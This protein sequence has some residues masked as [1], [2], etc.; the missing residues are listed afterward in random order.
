MSINDNKKEIKAKKS[1]S[2]DLGDKAFV[3]FVS[4]T[5]TWPLEYTKFLRQIPLYDY[6]KE[7][8]VMTALKHDI[9]RNGMKNMFRSSIPQSLSA[10]P[11]AVLRFSVYEALNGGKIGEAGGE[12]NKFKQFRNAF[13]AGGMEAFFVMTPIEVMKVQLIQEGTKKT[14]MAVLSDFY[15]KNG[16]QG[17]WKGGLSTTLRQAST[18]GVSIACYESIQNSVMNITGMEKQGASM[19]SGIL[20]GVLAVYANNPIDVIKTHQQS[21]VEGKKESIKEI[22]SNIVK[23]HGYKGFYNGA[24]IRASRVAPLHG[25]TYWLYEKLK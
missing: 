7:R 5:A 6:T 10:I 18:Q 4:Q 1:F 2:R 9:Q 3:G 19:T 17:F 12:K 25:L 23:K 8:N 14:G 15:K 13:I 11:R 24:L 16:I 20:A 21:H 22:C